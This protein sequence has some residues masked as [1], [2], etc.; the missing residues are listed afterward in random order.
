MIDTNTI[1]ISLDLGELSNQCKVNKYVE[2]IINVL[3]NKQVNIKDNEYVS[4]AETNKLII[5]VLKEVLNKINLEGID[6]G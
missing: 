5:L 4:L 2:K 1:L 3:Q 6:Y